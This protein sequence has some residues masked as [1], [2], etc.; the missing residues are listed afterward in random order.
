MRTCAFGLA[1]IWAA[2]GCSVNDVD[3]PV[4]LRFEHHAPGQML[5]YHLDL[6]WKKTEGA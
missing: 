1:V 2:A 3:R 6:K 5:I 4:T